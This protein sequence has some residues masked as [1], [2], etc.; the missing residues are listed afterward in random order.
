MSKSILSG[1]VYCGLC[2]SKMKIKTE[3]GNRKFICSL[4]A[5]DSTQCKRM[6]IPESEI[7]NL[8]HNRYENISYEK[9]NSKVDYVEVFDKIKTKESDI[10]KLTIHFHDDED[11]ILGDNLW[12]F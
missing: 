9:I 8:I 11:I 10:Y 4:Y 5:K 7:L 6:T 1:K 3:K 12:V 2:N